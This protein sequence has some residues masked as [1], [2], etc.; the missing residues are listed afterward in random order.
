MKKVG[1][2]FNP[3]YIIIIIIIIMWSL[4][5]VKVF[6]KGEE[7]QV[8]TGSVSLYKRTTVPSSF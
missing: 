2:I 3:C 8:R 6:H 5:H 1:M 7:S 4:S